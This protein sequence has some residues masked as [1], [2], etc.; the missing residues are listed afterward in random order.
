[1]KKSMIMLSFEMACAPAVVD[2]VDDFPIREV[3]RH[4]T[5]KEMF[6]DFLANGK[7]LMD[8]KGIPDGDETLVCTNW[9]CPTSIVVNAEQY[10]VE[11]NM[12]PRL[13]L[14]TFRIMTTNEPSIKVANGKIEK[15]TNGART[16][17]LAFANRAQTSFYLPDFARGVAVYN[18]GTAS[19]I[20]FV[21]YT[22]FPP[23]D[24]PEG[25]LLYKNIKLKIHAPTN[26][27][28]FAAAIINAGLPEE[29]RIPLPPAP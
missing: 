26:A 14:T 17:L 15:A 4:P 11:T 10:L 13:G 25:D 5:K 6:A 21:T 7:W 22:F 29:E 3:I 27:V 19:N 9:V 23:E 16:R 12:W 1:M 20:L 8:L 24:I 2:A 18:Y 28:D